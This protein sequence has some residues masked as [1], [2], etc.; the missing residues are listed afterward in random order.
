MT[1]LSKSAHRKPFQE[2]LGANGFYDRQMHAAV[3][4][5]WPTAGAGEVLL[6]GGGG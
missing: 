1:G 5:F 2:K 3:R 6:F 4:R